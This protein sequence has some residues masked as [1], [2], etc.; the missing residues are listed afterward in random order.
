MKKKENGSERKRMD[1][2]REKERY[3]IG[4]KMW[5]SFL[6]K[7]KLSSILEELLYTFRKIVFH[8]STNKQRKTGNIF[9][10]NVF[11][12]NRRSLND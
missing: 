12:Q 9:Q 7:E 1:D 11:C 4:R 5:H 8:L 2:W 3:G 6:I 10:K